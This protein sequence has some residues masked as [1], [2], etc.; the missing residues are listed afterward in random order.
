M[1]KLLM[2]FVSIAI[3]LSVDASTLETIFQGSTDYEGDCAFILSDLSANDQP[4]LDA[5]NE[6]I[7]E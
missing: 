4:Y 3:A 5:C 1:F 6:L 2:I 7:K